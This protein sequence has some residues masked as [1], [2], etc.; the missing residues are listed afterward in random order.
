MPSMTA[1]YAGADQ[2]GD[3]MTTISSWSMVWETIMNK[4]SYKD[5]PPVFAIMEYKT[6]FNTGHPGAEPLSPGI[7]NRSRPGVAWKFCYSKSQY[8]AFLTEGAYE[9][10]QFVYPYN[11]PEMDGKTQQKMLSKMKVLVKEL[12]NLEQTRGSL[13]L[14]FDVDRVLA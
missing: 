9:W 10:T 2:L 12:R 5:D 8:I 1:I 3:D 11:W 6:I 4:G 7:Q 13:V 14:G